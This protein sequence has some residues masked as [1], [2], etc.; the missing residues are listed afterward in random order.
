MTYTATEFDT[1]A[2]KEKF[3]LQF[4]RFVMSDF[5]ENKFPNWFYKSLSMTFGHIAHYN[6]AG[7]YST[8]FTSD[9]GKL[10]FLHQTL[11]WPCHG[12]PTF[13]YCDVERALSEW[14][15][16]SGLIENYQAKRATRVENQE[17]AELARL[18]TK[19]A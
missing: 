11:E 18:Q 6:K 4:K 19:Y 9:N 16:D 2:D 3:E 1:A 7:F 13:T 12:S 14:V 8:F 17:R 15:K 10:D 5:A